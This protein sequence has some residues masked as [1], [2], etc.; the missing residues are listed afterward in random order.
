LAL[1]GDE[2][3]D[4]V[5]FIRLSLDQPIARTSETVHGFL[6]DGLGARFVMDGVASAGRLSLVEHPIGPRGLAAAIHR[7]TRED[8]Y[9]FV[10]EGRWGFQLG[11]DAT[12]P[13][14]SVSLSIR[15]WT[16]WT[17]TPSI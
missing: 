1:A 13:S 3:L 9:S 5:T 17:T 8:E 7:H 15:R 4:G 16:P 6:G 14:S 11:D 12:E 10:L 2:I